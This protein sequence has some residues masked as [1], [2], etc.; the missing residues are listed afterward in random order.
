MAT[1]PFCELCQQLVTKV[2]FQCNQ[3]ITV[4]C[5]DC[6]PH[7]IFHEHPFPTTENMQDVEEDTSS[8]DEFQTS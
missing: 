7:L 8:T 5:V 3:C 2:G 4:V 1:P 6:L